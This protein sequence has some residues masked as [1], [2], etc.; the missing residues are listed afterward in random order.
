MSRKLVYFIETEKE[1]SGVQTIIPD[2]LRKMPPECDIQTYYINL[3]LRKECEENPDEII[4]NN[5]IADEHILNEDNYKETDENSAEFSSLKFVSLDECDF[6]EFKD[7]TF[8]VPINYLF[9]LLPYISEYKDA[10]ICPYIYDPKSIYNF[11]RQM[12][13]PNVNEITKMLNDTR[14]CMFI[15]KQNASG[16]DYGLDQY[17][18]CIIPASTDLCTALDKKKQDFNPRCISIGW[19]GDISATALDCIKRICEDLYKL[20]GE[21]EEGNKLNIHMFDFHIIGVGAVMGQINFKRYCPLIKFVFPGHLNDA[22]LDEYVCSNIDLAAGYN[23]NAVEGAMCE[24]PTIIPAINDEPAYAKRTYVYFKDAEDYILCWKKRELHNFVYDDYTMEEIIERLKADETRQKD[25]RDCCNFA[26]S[27]FSY[28]ENA[29]RIAEYTDSSSLTVERLLED[30]AIAGV[31]QQ[32]E[33]YRE[34]SEEN[35]EATYFDY[36]NRHRK[37]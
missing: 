11:F 31:L 18:E 19:I 12:R 3:S 34:S 29:K 9:F 21:D 14:S 36:F 32:L 27:H 7:A 10:K 8:I 16:W 2:I 20:Y 6:S 17:G 23:M 35:A 30:E 22:E 25:A 4:G 26:V 5:N 13:K 37:G 28:E 33:E 1:I 24:V 15:N